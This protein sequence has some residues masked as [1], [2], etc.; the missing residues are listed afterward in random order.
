MDLSA[1]LDL[2]LGF[3]LGESLGL[4]KEHTNKEDAVR[5]RKHGGW[6]IELEIAGIWLIVDCRSVFFICPI[7]VKNKLVDDKYLR[8]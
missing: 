5:E 1:D 4:R 8:I 3:G 2:R 7:L 6:G